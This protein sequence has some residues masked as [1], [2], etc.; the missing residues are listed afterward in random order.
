[1]HRG[2][3]APVPPLHPMGMAQ[4]HMQVTNHDVLACREPGSARRRQPI[5]MCWHAASLARPDAATSHV[6]GLIRLRV[7]RVD[8]SI[9]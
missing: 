1:M 5:M 2:S 3:L 6:P 4:R 9:Y 7:G 8:Y